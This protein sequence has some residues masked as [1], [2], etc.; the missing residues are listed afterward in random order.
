MNTMWARWA[1]AL[2]LARRD[3]SWRFRGLRLLIV[4][5][6]LG[7]AALSAIGTLEGAIRGE[8]ATRGQD[9]LGG[10]IEF[11]RYGQPATAQELSAM[12]ALGAV[13][14][15]VRMQAIASVGSGDDV[16]GAPVQLKAIDDAYPL[17][18]ELT[19]RDGRSVR[20]PPRGEAWV[21]PGLLDRL[22]IDEGASVRLGETQVRLTGLIE[23]EPDRLSEG[24]SLGP[25]MLISEATL[26]D[27]GLV[28]TGSMARFKYR[29]K[30]PADTDVEQTAEAFTE[31]FP[32]A[33]WEYRTR[34]RASPGADR[35]MANMGQFLTLVGLAALFIAGIGIAG[36]VTSW[37]ESRRTSI[38]TLKVLGASSG[39]VMRIHVVQV[40]AAALVGV[41]AGLVLGYLAVPVLASLLEG[42][43]PVEARFSFDVLALA[44][45]AGFALLV[46]LIFAAPPLIAAR[47]VTAMA[48]FRSGAGGRIAVWRAAALPVGIG[49]AL[50]IALVLL[51]ARDPLLNLWFIVGAAAMLGLLAAIGLGIKRMARVLPKTGAGLAV[52]M[53]LSSLDRP[54]APTVALATALGFGLTAFAAIAS[55]Q[56]ALDRYVASSVPEVAPDYF[57]IDLPSGDVD[58]FAGLVER[59]APGSGVRAVPNLRATIIAY[60]PADAMTYVEDLEDVP[61]GAWALNG[62]RGVTY[63]SAVPDGNTVTRGEW[64]SE[65]QGAS[66]ALVSVDEELARPI[67]LNIGDRLRYSVLGTER[68]AVVASFR[69]IEW[70]DLGFNHVLVFSP[71]AIADAPH[72]YA[73]TVSLAKGADRR[74]L[75][76]AMV[77]EFPGSAVIEVGAVLTQAR[78]I[79]G[80]M[81]AAI[82]AAASVTVLAGLAVLLGAIA[83][84]RA[85]ETYETVVLRVLGAS[86]AQVLGA[87]AVRYALLAGLLALVALALGSLVGWGVM[88]GLFD[89]PFRPDWALVLGVLAGG[90]A[91]VIVAATAAS[92]PVLRARP[93]S[94]LRSL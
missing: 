46:A 42:M 35:L 93:A 13:S 43:L 61:E 91:L 25:P 62:E 78:D 23:S 58:R 26:A 7:A 30:R 24:F 66:E 6:F 76:S 9:I 52:R 65:G 10:D 27:A 71:G 17:Y 5:L 72:N 77:R 53:G 56:S 50:L 64:W 41:I 70:D 80:S 55:I 88:T 1:L 83:A 36:A 63:A 37:L 8:L 40:V 87:L 51:G 67:G 28:Q 85:R 92:I 2:R 73:A 12:H 59:I 82:L 39:D 18:G 31:R 21:D 19:L 29:V 68:E 47:E 44:R 20:A 54:G 60:G 86:R 49:I 81:A 89:L 57:V 74:A 16:V 4:C 33:G 79:L 32:I 45:A 15:G 3:F 69:T 48:L 22:D 75:L 94:A 11:R 34:D 84:A 38:A 90:A 14:G